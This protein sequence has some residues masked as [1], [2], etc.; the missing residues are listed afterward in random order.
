MASFGFFQV[1]ADD[2]GRAKKF[3]QSL[4]GWKIEPATD[5]E[6][7]SL[8]WQNVI[9]GTPETGMMNEGGLY[10]RMGPAPIMNFALVE[11][12]DKVLAKVEKLGGKVI[13]PKNEIKNVGTVAVIQD[14]EGN[15]LGV[16]K[17]V[18]K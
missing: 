2:V 17:P 16:W 11:D 3:Y 18:E 1:P 10:K 7:T 12:I 6:D 5:L 9:T 14:T 4:L 13:M 15:I 8:Q